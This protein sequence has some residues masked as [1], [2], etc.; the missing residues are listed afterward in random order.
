M[1]SRVRDFMFRLN[2]VIEREFNDASNVN[3][4]YETGGYWFARPNKRLGIEG[5]GSFGPIGSFPTTDFQRHSWG[6]AIKLIFGRVA[7]DLGLQLGWT[8]GSDYAVVKS[9]IDVEF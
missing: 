7:W 5:F 4:G 1:E 8:H 2:P 3:F 6:P 9:I